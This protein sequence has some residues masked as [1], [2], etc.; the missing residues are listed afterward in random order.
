MA[1]KL[2]V[3][4]KVPSGP[5][6]RVGIGYNISKTLG[7]RVLSSG[8]CTKLDNETHTV[9]IGKGVRKGV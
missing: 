9:G 3:S 4:Q 2:S 1:Q 7:H 6:Q 5:F 8:Q